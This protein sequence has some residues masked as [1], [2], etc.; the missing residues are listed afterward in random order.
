[1][2]NEG[3]LRPSRPS[4]IGGLDVLRGTAIALVLLRHAAPEFF[5]GAGIVGVLIFFVMSGYLISSLLLADLSRYGRVRLARFY[6]NRAIR[7]LPP[8]LVF[9]CG[10]S[11]VSV[12]WNPLGDVGQL[13]RAL[14]MAL[15]YT[16]NLPVSVGSPAVAHLWTLATEE[17]FY[18]VWPFVVAIAF[19][20]GHYWRWIISS[21]VLTYAILVLS[22]AMTAP[23]VERV[24]GVFTSWSIALLAGAAL[25]FMTASGRVPRD[26]TRFLSL[27]VSVS[28]A[29]LALCCVLPDLKSEWWGYL[30]VGP[31]VAV[32]ALVCVAAATRWR[33]PSRLW[34]PM[35]WLGT[36]SYA[37]YLWNY[38]IVVWFEALSLPFA[39]ILAIPVTLLLAQLSWVL[40][41]APLARW[42]FALDQRERA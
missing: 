24:Y 38:P 1:M 33:S 27:A 3:V 13:P 30:V 22:L 17:Q 5:G 32:A 18:L 9:L 34:G 37:A 12:L 36:I 31:V 41:E 29:V 4:R 39:G 2:R 28:L 26:R 21:A 20:R 25:A 10:L 19:R 8:L 15:T 11:L 35:I 23:N 40:L 14:L 7:L 16:A 6:R 42:R